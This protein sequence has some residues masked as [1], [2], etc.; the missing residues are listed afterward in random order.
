MYK[1]Q[2][3]LKISK[4]ERISLSSGRYLWMVPF[5]C[6]QKGK[7]LHF[8]YQKQFSVSYEEITPPTLKGHYRHFFP[9]SNLNLYF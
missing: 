6:L 3:F 5:Y 1:P 4:I 9:V 8:H 2:T 7:I